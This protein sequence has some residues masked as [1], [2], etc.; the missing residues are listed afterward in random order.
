MGY[1]QKTILSLEQIQK[2][3]Q[4]NYPLVKGKELLRQ[5][6]GLTI[7]NIRTSYLP[8]LYANGKMS[9]QSDVTSSPIAGPNSFGAPKEQFAMNL[10]VEQL[11]YNGGK[12]KN[13]LKLDQ[14]STEVEVI[15]LEVKMYELRERVNDAFFSILL[16]RQSSQVLKEKRKSVTARL[17]QVHSAVKNGVMA[18]SNAK[19]LESEVLLIDQQLKELEYAETTSFETLAELMNRN[20]EFDI[21]H[22]VKNE[23]TA[24]FS[25]DNKI[26]EE[27]PEYRLFEG[28]NSLLDEQ[29]EMSKKDKLPIITAFG[30][31][32]YGQPGY[33]QLN[34]EFDTYYMVGAKLSWNIFDWK[35][36]KRKQR[37]YQL[38]KDL[39]MTQQFSF[40]KNQKIELH[41]ELNNITKFKILLEQD[42]AIVTLKEEVTKSSSS[43]LDN[44]VITSSD[45]LEDLN[46]E[47]QAKLNREYHQIQLSQ[48]IKEYNRILGKTNIN[49]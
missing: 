10:D 46:K 42:N 9:Y 19:V 29:I 7:E 12:T 13:Q 39:V 47:I 33:N 25:I 32:G 34:D 37:K 36:S 1:G 6:S 48:A 16:L 11:I 14:L 27:R 15:D 26:S 17:E 23:S 2:E 3:V 49:I 18:A 24:K 31:V 22:S 38:Q 4:E 44:G 21:D 35:T 5:Q 45:Y 20:I 40:Q 41:R 43:Q 28:Q 30:Q 8:K